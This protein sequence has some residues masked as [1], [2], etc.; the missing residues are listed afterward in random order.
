MI[1]I[2]HLFQFVARALRMK[3]YCRP[4]ARVWGSFAGKFVLTVT[5]LAS[6]VNTWPR[7]YGQSTPP[8]TSRDRLARAE[9]YVQLREFSKAAAELDDLLQT[10][11]D[12][13]PEA[14][15]LL[16][17]SHMKM[18]QKEKALAACDQG[19]AHFHA[20]K[21]LSEF[22]VS[23]VE[24]SLPA[25]ECKTRLVRFLDLAPDSPAF[26][27]ALGQILMQENPGSPEGFELLKR[28][29]ATSPQD[30]EA[31]FLYGKSLCFAKQFEVCI[32]QLDKARRLKPGNVQADLQIFTMIG[33]AEDTL[34]DAE[35][36]ESAFLKAM[37]ANRELPQ[38]N[39]EAA[40]QY[41]LFLSRQSKL[42]EMKP[43]INNV[44]SWD[45]AYGAAHFERAKLLFKEHK[46]EEAAKEAELALA[47][48]RS[49]GTEVRSYHAFL[50]KT[51]FALGRSKE[52]EI[53]QNWVESHQTA[54]EQ[55]PAARTSD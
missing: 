33:I 38:H 50:A 52:A 42:E 25:A 29:S 2:S 55:T 21:N 40:M 27:K 5:L 16:G 12:A 54:T 10:R 41:I 19:L 43:I 14:Y 36:A 26:L 45:P 51:Y 23:V 22:C 28:A 46:R 49:N 1:E 8:S 11:P 15:I 30:A 4:T 53:H 44:L 24:Q 9:H 20:D 17:V 18:G 7:L 47:D 31:H 34:N 13:D 39:P 37:Q 3:V 35:K 6:F 48:A 32:V